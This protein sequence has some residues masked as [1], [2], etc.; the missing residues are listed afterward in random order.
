MDDDAVLRA[1]DRGTQFIIWFLFISATFSVLVRLGI[2]Y[3]MT[4]GLAADGKLII[5]VLFIY[6]AQCIAIS[7]ATAA[8]VGV[9][10]ATN[11][12]YTED[13]SSFLKRANQES[14]RELE[15][16]SA[17]EPPASSINGYKASKRGLANAFLDAT[18][19]RRALRCGC[20]A[21]LIWCGT[22]TKRHIHV[23]ENLWGWL[24][25]VG[26]YRTSNYVMQKA[27]DNKPRSTAGDVLYVQQTDDMAIP[28]DGMKELFESKSGHTVTFEKL[29]VE[30]GA[31]IA[32]AA[33]IHSAVAAFFGKVPRLPRALCSPRFIKTWKPEAS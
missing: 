19:S 6:L 15:A 13:N 26:V 23:S 4:Y 2:K 14:T 10:A 11:S 21:H 8:D 18:T 5:G 12:S 30:E 25:L 1:N 24:D 9:P 17:V 33:G 16:A 7:I 32:N 3:A 20:A 22:T 29:T 31:R 28:I 27:V